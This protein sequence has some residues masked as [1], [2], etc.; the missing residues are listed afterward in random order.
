M[1][2]EV[3][4]ET[5]CPFP[6]ATGI[7]RYL[8]VFERSHASS[9]FEAVNSA[10]LLW[11]HRDDRLPVDKM[12]GHRAFS[13]ASTGDSDIPS[14]CEMKDEPAFKSLQGNP[15]F[16]RFKASQCPFQLGQKTQG[17]SH[18]H[19]AERILLLWC[20]WKVGIPLDSKTGN[21]L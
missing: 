10:Y 4:Q 2:L 8:S 11:S 1:T 14:S 16:F 9:P 17:P 5:Q 19:I 13:R 20:L 6:V 15:A 12:R 7:L 21:Q 18:I 3:R